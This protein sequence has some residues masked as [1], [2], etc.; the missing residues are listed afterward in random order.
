M[1]GAVALAALAVAV[2]LMPVAASAQ[3]VLRNPEDVGEIRGLRLGQNIPDMDSEPFG[4]FACGSNGGAPRQK[5]GGF[6][7]YMRCRAEPD[8]LHEVWIRFS[9]ADE[10]YARAIDH[11]AMIARVSGT[12]VAGFQVILSVLFD[13]GGTVRGIRMVTD[14]RAPPNERGTAF[15]FKRRI[16]LRYG[17]QDWQCT[18]IPAAQGETPVAGLF[19]KADCK[20]ETP[21]RTLYVQARF[22]RKAGQSDYDPVT[23]EPTTGQYESSTRFEIYDPAYPRR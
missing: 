3:P 13:D 15:Q 6:G 18:D 8:G 10:L 16:E 22:F 11:E 1:R 20:K 9:D 14:P 2:A 17:P 4:E 7:D 5:I 21:E 12:R 19:V 23:R